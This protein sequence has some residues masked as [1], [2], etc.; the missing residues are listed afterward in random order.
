MRWG[1]LVLLGIALVAACDSLKASQQQA[2]DAGSASSSSGK[3]SGAGASGHGTDDDD[4]AEED[5]DAGADAGV[6]DCPTG[7]CVLAA[8]RL[9][10]ADLA[11]RAGVVFWVEQGSAAKAGKD[12]RVAWAPTSVCDAG[13]VTER[14]DAGPNLAG[15][16]VN[17]SDVFLAYTTNGAPGRVVRFALDGGTA[18]VVGDTEPGARHI[19]LSSTRA[20]WTSLGDQAGAGKVRVG[21][22]DDSP[23]VLPPGTI[24]ENL[25]YPIGI[26]VSG[27]LVFF[28]V[29]GKGAAEGTTV[30]NGS[31]QRVEALGSNRMTLADAQAQPRGIAVDPTFVYWVNRGDGTVHRVRWDGTESKELATSARA[32]ISIAVDSDGIYWAE[33][34]TAPEYA[35]GRLRRADLDGTN[36]ATI[37]DV[38]YPVAIAV[39]GNHVYAASR[40]TFANAF[41]DGT[42][43]KVRKH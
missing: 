43:V 6:D 14:A 21:A 4:S 35:D 41:V 2:P 19:G 40:G 28:S 5:E 13:C 33:S 20:F 12:G 32:P 18:V 1:P 24:A 16:A 9:S 42:I 10:P 17:A 31:I 37:A 29:E 38:P 22:L 34:G 3:T 7:V 15:L 25:D 39:S 30:A 11:V 36:A 27:D 23:P 8:N 26:A